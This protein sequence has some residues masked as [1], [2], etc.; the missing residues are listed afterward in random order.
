MTE[1]EQGMTAFMLQCEIRRRYCHFSST[2]RLLRSAQAAA[3]DRIGLSRR[4]AI[5]AIGEQGAA[6]APTARQLALRRSN[7]DAI[8]RAAASSIPASAAVLARDA[9]AHDAGGREPNARFVAGHWRAN[10]PT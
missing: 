7:V 6:S 5:V 1:L 8:S 9:T 4:S 10:V 2:R 3:R